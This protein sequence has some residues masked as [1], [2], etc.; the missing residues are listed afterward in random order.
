MGSLLRH[1]ISVIRIIL[2]INII[3]ESE[4]E[5]LIHTNPFWFENHVF[6]AL[7]LLASCFSFSGLMNDDGQITCR[8]AQTCTTND[9]DT[10]IHPQ[11]M[12]LKVMYVI[13]RIIYCMSPATITIPS[14][15]SYSPSSFWYTQVIRLRCINSW[16]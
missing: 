3:Y 9:R 14:T 6:C 13:T 5:C 16:W 8:T 7:L 2:I 1:K 12:R 10:L 15:S 11:R 4:R